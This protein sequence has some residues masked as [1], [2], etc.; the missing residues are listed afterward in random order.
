M[1]LREYGRILRRRLWIPIVLTL[2][3]AALSAVQ[4]RPWQPAPPSGY[5]TEIRLLLG[6]APMPNADTA[7]YDPRYF[8]WLISE[9]LVDDFTEVVRSQLFAT[10]ISA[11]LTEDGITVPAGAITGSATTG[12]QHRII[13]LNFAWPDQTEATAIANA[14]AAELKENASVYFVQLGTD[15]TLIEILDGPNI[16]PVAGAPMEIY[17]FPIRVLLALLAGL[18]LAFLVEYLDDSVRSGHDLEALGVT[19]IGAIPK[20]R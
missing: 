8:A 6:V 15:D 7:S 12:K 13:T 17:E 14:A 1:E 10:G 20:H 16:A 11:R 19:T 9:Y 2:L 4:L 18:A 3:V 5:N